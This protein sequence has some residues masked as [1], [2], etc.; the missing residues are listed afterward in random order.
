MWVTLSE[1][2][3]EDLWDEQQVVV[4]DPNKIA[5]L[6]EVGDALSICGVGIKIMLPRR[7]L[8]TLVL[9]E[10]D[11]DLSEVSYCVS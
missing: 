6:I 9:E 11:K 10:E 8:L 7:R 5:R 2:L 1:D 4:M 3:S